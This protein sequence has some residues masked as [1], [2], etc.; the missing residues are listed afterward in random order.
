MSKRREIEHRLRSLSEIKDIMGA[1]KNLSLMEIRKL[2][3]FL[4]TQH[5]V[6]ASIQAAAAD[7]LHFYP[8]GMP[9]QS[10]VTGVY[11]LIGSE[12]GFCG[13]FNEALLQ[14]LERCEREASTL[15]SLIIAVGHR[16]S[17]RLAQ[18]PRVIA[19][20]DGP[21]VAE[22]V[23][24]V[25]I[26]LMETLS[27]QAIQRESLSVTTLYHSEGGVTVQSLLPL[28]SLEHEAVRFAFPPLVN[29]SPREFFAELVDHYL[30][31]TLHDV[32]YTSLMVENRW[33]LQH[34]ESAIQHLEKE[35][36]ALALKRNS[37]RQE[38]ITEDIEVIMLSAEE[39]RKSDSEGLSDGQRRISDPTR[40]G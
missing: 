9:S 7:F 5:K 29:L 2:T 40:R 14:T 31:A 11:L 17:N 28:P 26:H 8:E 36:V 38:E 4:G 27:R 33:R 32:F 6:I 24:T 20:L 30:Y 16:L 25:L 34:M 18:H 19:H 15:D 22:E 3:R 13:D 12:R 1:M 39:V 21:S 10:P 37:L 35:S 23:G